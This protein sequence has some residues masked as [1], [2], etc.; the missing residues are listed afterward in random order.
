MTTAIHHSA[1]T[2]FS[3][4]AA[5]YAKGRPNYPPGVADWLRA[6]LALR[7]G[8]TGLDLGAGT[9]KFLPYLEATGA[10]IVAVEPVTAM[11]AELTARHPRITALEGTA[12]RIPLADATL[13]AVVCAQSFHWF[14][15]PEALAD[16]RRVLK[17]GGR[18]GLIWNNRDFS[19]PWVAAIEAVTEPYV[20]DAPSQKSGAWRKLF[21]AD[22]F[23]TLS[24]RT[25]EHGHRGHP[26]IVIIE[27]I[28]SVSYV[29][30]LPDAEQQRVVEKIR[31]IIATSPE[32]AGRSDVTFPYRTTAFHCVKVG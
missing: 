30:A 20:G 2:G 27:R 9:G 18:L 19:T 14:A 32:L 3:A 22:G 15:T 4:K 8:K 28:L 23:G 7:E 26:E 24:E 10:T 21:P 1:L 17:P 16:I 11:R 6:D 25:F 12:T 5:S 13:D 29:A 31:A